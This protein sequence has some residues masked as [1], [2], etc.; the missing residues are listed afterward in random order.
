MI[1]QRLSNRYDSRAELG[2]GG[3]GVVYRAHDPL[4]NREVAIK[5]IPPT[6]LSSETEQRFQREAQLVAQMDHPA[7]VPIFDFGKDE[8]SL[9]FVMPIVQGTTLRWYQR[10]NPL[11]LGEVL[12]IGIQAAEALEYSHSRGVIHRDVKPEN[13]M[14]VREEGARIRVRIMDFGLARGATESRI[15]KTGTIAGTLSYMSPEQVAGGVIDHR[16]D[17]Y[18]LGTVLYECLSGEPPF[19]GELQ[20]VLY[21]IVHEIPQSPRVVGADINEEL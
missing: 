20:S 3:G 11:T 16:S 4:L 21:R 19:S 18:S 10:D 9:F 13:I 6:L 8:G 7:V 17:I 5:L 12:D 15:T 1:G 2:R 14:V